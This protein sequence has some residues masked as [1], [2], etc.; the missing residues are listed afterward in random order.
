MTGALRRERVMMILSVLRV[1]HDSIVTAG[2]WKCGVHSES[3]PFTGGEAVSP[4][5]GEGSDR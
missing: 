4:K 3:S 2:L 5:A 1:V